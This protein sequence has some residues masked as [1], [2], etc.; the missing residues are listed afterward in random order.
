MESIG[1]SGSEECIAKSALIES[2]DV[3]VLLLPLGWNLDG[4]VNDL[5]TSCAIM[6]NGNA[7]SSLDDPVI[8]EIRLVFPKLGQRH[9]LAL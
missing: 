4:I 7:Y 2:P 1:C 3:L 5:P 9:T 8:F 6:V